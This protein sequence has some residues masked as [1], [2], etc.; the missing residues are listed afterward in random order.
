MP[1]AFA[2]GTCGKPY[3]VDER[4]AGK[5]AACRACGTVNNIPASG[6]NGSSRAGAA[7]PTPLQSEPVRVAS[8]DEDAF[9]LGV[10]GEAL[11]L[12]AVEPELEP[13][14]VPK[15]APARRVVQQPVR[16]LPV[17]QCP[18]C[19]S[20]LES[21][22]VFCTGCGFN[23][24]TGKHV[25]T[26][27]AADDDDGAEPHPYGAPAAGHDP[28]PALRTTAFWLLVS[29]GVFSLIV[30]AGLV[31]RPLAVLAFPA[32]IVGALVGMVGAVIYFID[33][34]MEGG[35]AG[36]GATLVAMVL[37]CTIGMRS[38]A[39]V[40]VAPPPPPPV[41]VAATM[42]TTA[43][44]PGPKIAEVSS[45]RFSV[46][47]PAA[48]EDPVAYWKPELHDT[49]A[50]VRVIA[51]GQLTQVSDPYREGAADA[52]AE[53]ASDEDVVARRAAI[54][55]L[56]VA[57]TPGSLAAAIKGL[58]DKDGA[59]ARRAVKVLG[60]FQDESAIAPLL[61]KYTTLG[62]PVLAAL[63]SYN[64]PTRERVVEA[65]KSLMSSADTKG[66]MA[67][68]NKL[69]DVD[70]ATAAPLL[71]AYVGDSD[72]TVRTA[73]IG[74]LADL[75][76]EPAIAPI[77]ERLR[78]D[79]DAAAQALI[80]FGAPAEAAVAAK[81]TDG[82]PKQR[83]LVMQILR[84]IATPASLPA[85]KSAA[86]DANLEVALAARE[87]W[88]R[89]EPEAL[90][91]INEAVMD[92]DGE[93]DLLIRALGALAKLPVDEERQ[94]LV[95][96]KLYDIVMGNGEKPI[97]DLACSALVVWADKVTRERMLAALKPDADDAKRAYA[98]RLAV[99]FKD[100][101]AVRPLC[102]CLAAGRD[103]P[104]VWDGLREFGTLSETF[105]MRLVSTG[106]SGLRVKLFNLLRD[107][108]T[109]RCFMVIAP[110][111]NNKNT[112][113]D[114]KKAAKET[115]IA[116]NRRLNSA[117]ARK[118]PPMMPARPLPPLPPIQPGAN[119]EK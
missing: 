56:S 10:M 35:L 43:P 30:I 11:E 12:A 80:K 26:S 119:A 110:L 112:D 3:K 41:V 89:L 67:I 19:G 105:L 36:A 91:P 64:G 21:G 107:V 61:A 63:A 58:D 84:S 8:D 40:A 32:A 117:A 92:L 49:D 88:R 4:F 1:I 82:E 95:S 87:V 27:V 69:V 28:T 25:S 99:E 109:R 54:S 116:I 9:P 103:M 113:A 101:R 70:P 104:E 23:L 114:L 42:R 24:K 5:K 78:D 90:T 85:I 15:P 52:I 83:L 48:G 14:P 55:G 37:L 7:Q 77:V 118:A 60:Q 29:C 51:I 106:D 66:R 57:K 71:A 46:R 81:L 74:L 100:P 73:A 39:P 22:A 44:D 111:A 62:D 31:F 17:D 65:Y 50:R 76:Y 86:K 2:C 68:I 47:P 97:P 115:I 20:P 33:G 108:G 59:V 38:N 96:K 72:A 75:R 79:P 94:A 98:I 6:G 13:E 45:G 93:K 102:E 16:A 53:L 34:A 18:H